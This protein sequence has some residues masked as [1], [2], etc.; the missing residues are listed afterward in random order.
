MDGPDHHMR[1][2][3]FELEKR[4]GEGT[5]GVVYRARELATGRTVALKV[6]YPILAGNV[7]YLQRFAAE[8]EAAH[9]LSHPNLVAVFGTGHQGINYYICM[10]YVDGQNLRETI[11]DHGALP[12]MTVTALGMCV[13]S[14]L[15]YAWEKERLIHRDVK[16]ENIL[17]GTD[18]SVKLCDMGIAKRMAPGAAGPKLTRTGY[19][20]GTPHYIAPEQ[21]KGGKDLDCR[22]DIY[23]LGATLYNAA[24]GQT[25]HQADDEYSLLMKQISEP[26]R[27]PRQVM[28]ELTERFALLL[29]N[30]LELDRDKRCPDWLLVYN[31]LEAIYQQAAANPAKI[32]IAGPADS[33]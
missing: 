26:V 2:E 20:L 18:G 33:A 19:V 25:I 24:T 32:R 9:R 11:R 6:L 1:I 8:A 12:E 30:M 21:L 3:G 27:D 10:E 23:A 15:H 16:P 5:M 22:V 13:A 31:E 28:P 17:I 14:A 29:L 7:T 4:L